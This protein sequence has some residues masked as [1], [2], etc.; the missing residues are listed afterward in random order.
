MLTHYRSGLFAATPLG[1]AVLYAVFLVCGLTP[2][3]GFTTDTDI[4]GI[5]V[6]HH[7]GDVDWHSV[8][9][10]GVEFVYLKATEG[11]GYVDPRYQ[12]HREALAELPV[13][14]GAYHYFHADHDPEKQ[15]QNFIR[16]IK[17]GPALDLP[18]AVDVEEAFGRSADELIDKL[19][20]WITL[21]E[22]ELGATPIIYTV[23]GFADRGDQ[24]KAGNK[25]RDLSHYPLW[26]A[27][28]DT[29]RLKLPPVL[30]HFQWHIWQFGQ[31]TVPGIETIVDLNTLNCEALA[32]DI[33]SRER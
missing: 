19:L 16:V 1:V 33:C 11:R 23:T 5:D 18:P 8:H 2:V 26:Y 27:K 17:G 4:L 6:S 29:D 14:V 31:G 24:D 22:A 30:G 15:A 28:Y 21:V 3:S 7:Q 25:G 12:S 20:T 9:R 10:H 13:R 32:H